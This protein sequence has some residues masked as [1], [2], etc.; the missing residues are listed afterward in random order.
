MGRYQAVT[1]RETRLAD[2]LEA[3][4]V[5]AWLF[6]VDTGQ[7][8]WEPT[9]FRIF[10]M[11]PKSAL[12]LDDF[13]EKVHPEDRPSVQSAIADTLAGGRYEKT[14]RIAASEG[15]RWIH[16]RA[17]RLRGPRHQRLITG[18]T[19]DVTARMEAEVE[20]E[21]LMSV[22]E[23]SK[24]RSALSERRADLIQLVSGVLH[25]LNSPLGSLVSSTKTLE[26]AVGRISAELPTEMARE[27]RV[28]QQSLSSLSQ[29]SER[30]ESSLS[31]LRRFSR[32]DR[33]EWERVEVTECIETVL[34]IL[35]PRPG[36]EVRFQPADFDDRVRCRP[37]EIQQALLTLFT[38]ALD[39]V[40]R[41]QGSG[42]D[43]RL[44]S[45]RDSVAIVVRDDGDGIAPEAIEALF[46]PTIV[47]KAGAKRLR[48]GLPIAARIA[49]DHGG[50]LKLNSLGQGQ[51]VTACL[52][53]RRE[54]P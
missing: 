52:S 23:E 36:I 24:A 33:A 9:M 50:S 12:S 11:A 45:A 54:V 53:I 38:N 14:Y 28:I 41:N 48:L 40:E 30:L 2:A 34:A 13:L 3:A 17:E 20:R 21:R 18:I 43:I 4:Q 42:V 31:T 7:L 44:E 22:L 10:D 5:G 16:A 46:H 26:I 49:E 51:G 27:C 25:E 6:D 19:I 1:E 35:P 47:E 29:A 39:A 32:P 37:V 15:I 8:T